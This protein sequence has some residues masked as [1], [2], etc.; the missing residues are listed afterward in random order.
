MRGAWKSRFAGEVG[1]LA[2]ACIGYTIWVDCPCEVRLRRGVERDGER[3][4]AVW[5]EEWMPA[6][7]LYVEA[8]VK[9]LYKANE[10]IKENPE[11]AYEVMAK[12]VGGWLK[13]PKRVAVKSGLSSCAIPLDCTPYVPLV[14]AEQEPCEPAE[15]YNCALDVV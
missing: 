7:D 6:E 10:F 11:K 14:G 5:V 2:A 9:G 3:M 8:L 1:A 12:G 4:R 15:S 13:D